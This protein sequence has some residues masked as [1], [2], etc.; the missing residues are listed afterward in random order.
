MSKT[1]QSKD[2]LGDRMKE[3]YENRT[4]ILLP[5][6]IY[7]IIRL[8]G[9]AFHSYTRGLQRPFD[10]GLMDDMDNTAKFLCENIQGCKL[11]Y[12]QSDEI[13]LVLA[14][15]DDI[16]TEAWFDGN[17]QKITSI[18]AAMAA[19][20]FNQLRLGRTMIPNLDEV[21]ARHQEFPNGK[22]WAHLLLD[23]NP[24][25][26]GKLAF[27]D[28]RVFTIPDPVEVENYLIWRQQDATRNSIQMAAQSMF[29]HKELQGVNCNQLQEKMWSERAVNWY[30]YPDG[31]KRGRCVVKETYMAPIPNSKMGRPDYSTSEVERTRWVVEAPPIFTQDRDYI[32]KRLPRH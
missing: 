10:Q 15:F 12:V 6:R 31:F 32:R 2:S 4:R 8:D 25:I 17:V 21:R 22:N 26:E 1:P 19:A 5:R 14:D 11:A 28:S 9:K 27:F 3:Q 16:T 24:L 7:T 30:D 13:S 20:K 23:P 18:S 29:S